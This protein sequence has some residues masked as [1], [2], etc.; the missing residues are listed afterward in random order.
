MVDVKSRN[1]I[2]EGCGKQPS[3]GVAGTETAEYCSQHAPD[4]IVDVKTRKYLTKGCGKRPLFEVAGTKTGGGCAQHAPDEMVH[5]YSRQCRVA[6]TRTREYCAQHARR[7]CG[8]EG[9]GKREFGPHGSGK[10]TIGNLI[11]CGAKQNTVHPS[12]KASRPSGGNGD[13]RKRVQHLDIT[14]TASKRTVSR[15]SAGGVETVPDIDGQTS[16]VKRDSSVKTE[17]QLSL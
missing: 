9:Y 11:T 10:E 5:V 1:C 2:T 16:P 15:G 6:N 7:K 12:P 14:F 13:S 3:L 4:G 8:V 17:V